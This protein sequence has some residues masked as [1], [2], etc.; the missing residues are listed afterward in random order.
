MQVWTDLNASKYSSSLMAKYIY[1]L[2]SQKMATKISLLVLN[3]MMKVKISL[4]IG[5]EEVHYKPIL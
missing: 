1:W 3:F 2:G 4:N 5:C